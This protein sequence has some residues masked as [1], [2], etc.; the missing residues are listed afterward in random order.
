MKILRTL[1]FAA[2]LGLAGC[3]TPEPSGAQA[4]GVSSALPSDNSKAGA[5]EQIASLRAAA[6]GSSDVII[7][8]AEPLSALLENRSEREQFSLLTYAMGTALRATTASPLLTTNGENHGRA[9]I[10]DGPHGMVITVFASD[11]PP[12][13]HGVHLHQVGDCS[14]PGAGFKAS[15]GHI[16]VDEA[17]HGILNPKGYHVGADFPN[18]WAS[19]AGITAELFAAGL[20]F[21][22]ALDEDGFALI[23]HENPDDHISQPIGGAGARIACAAFFPEL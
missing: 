6:D 8:T 1:V 19:E 15:G 10:I 14:D 5:E 2:A 4:E 3:V 18:V 11:I 21:E 16:G 7:I 13:F 23:I 17:E 12:G 22:Q 9:T 20:T